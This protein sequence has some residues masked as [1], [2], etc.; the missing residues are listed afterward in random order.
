VQDDL[1]NVGTFIGRAVYGTNGYVEAWYIKNVTAGSRTVTAT[2]S[3]TI[4][5]RFI[6]VIEDSADLTAPFD[7]TSKLESQDSTNPHCPSL[8]TGFDNEYCV[9]F[10]AGNPAASLAASGSYGDVY[11]V[12]FNSWN[13]GVADFQQ[14]SAGATNATWTAAN[15]SWFALMATFK[16]GAATAPADSGI[17]VPLDT[18]GPFLRY[19]MPRIQP[20]ARSDQTLSASAGVYVLTGVS[21][22]F[23]FGTKASAGSYNING[24]N[25]TL[26]YLASGALNIAPLL[27]VITVVGPLPRFRVP[28]Y[29][30][31]ESTF[32]FNTSMIASSGSYTIIGDAITLLFAWVSQAVPGAYNLVGKFTQL[33]S[34]IV[35]PTP[36]GGGVW[37]RKQTKGRVRYRPLAAPV[38]YA[39]D[40]SSEEVEAS[41]KPESKGVKELSESEAPGFK[42]AVD[43]L[44]TGKNKETLMKGFQRRYGKKK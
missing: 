3:A 5:N 1:S 38:V 22:T 16:A 10:A 37:H 30:T 41:S 17:L 24:I 13:M 32:G 27:P 18:R 44:K 9:G 11:V 28:K 23:A 25:A 12:S 7:Q 19:R 43:A 42:D 36:G 31:V 26:I 21:T 35:T 40:I 39:D 20:S 29:K 6:C 8:T 34:P 2:Y 33:I 15:G 14:T 4:T